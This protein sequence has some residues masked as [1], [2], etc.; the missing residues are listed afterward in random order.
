[1]PGLQEIYRVG[2]RQFLP[3]IF[4]WFCRLSIQFVRW[5]FLSVGCFELICL[6]YFEALICWLLIV[7][8]MAL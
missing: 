4:V 1:M 3:S 6:K 5:V 8:T 7:S 2:K